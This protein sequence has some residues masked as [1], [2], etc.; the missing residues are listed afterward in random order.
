ML[1][2]VLFGSTSSISHSSVFPAALI[3]SCDSLLK[4]LNAR[5]QNLTLSTRCHV[6]CGRQ[7]LWTQKGFIGIRSL[8]YLALQ[9]FQLSVKLEVEGAEF[10][11]VWSRTWKFILAADSANLERVIRDQGRTTQVVLSSQDLTSILQWTGEDA[12]D[13]LCFH[14]QGEQNNVC[15]DVPMRT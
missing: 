1:C 2:I 13:G 4:G 15:F 10:R 11:R 3:T 9:H 8:R 7:F 5:L 6:H 14:P 12:F